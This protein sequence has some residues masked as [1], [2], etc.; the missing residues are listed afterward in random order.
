MRG[1]RDE[2][3]YPVA[4]GSLIVRRRLRERDRHAAASGG[5][6]DPHADPFADHHR[7]GSSC[8][9]GDVAPPGDAVPGLTADEAIAV[10]GAANPNFQLPEGATSQLGYY[11]AAVGDGT[12]RHKD[13]LAWGLT[14]HE[15]IHSGE[16]S[17]SPSE[18]ILSCTFWMFLDA[19]TGEG[20][21]GE[22]QLGA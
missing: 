9:Y 5:I 20:L 3:G 22:W 11:T 7:I 15:C 19:N 8:E 10:Y 16:L 13:Q 18:S 21:E 2:D 1:A 14:W 17:E 12:Y 6:L 4:G